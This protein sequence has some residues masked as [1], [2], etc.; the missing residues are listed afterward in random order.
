MMLR[1]FVSNTVQKLARRYQFQYQ[2]VS[3]RH[4]GVFYFILTRKMMYGGDKL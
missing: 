3:T 4:D 2:L 1:I